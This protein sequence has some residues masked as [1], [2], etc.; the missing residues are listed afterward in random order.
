MRTR[1]SLSLLQN[2]RHGFLIATVAIIA[3]L[4]SIRTYVPLAD[5]Y[6]LSSRFADPGGLNLWIADNAIHRIGQFPIAWMIM[7]QRNWTPSLIS[8]TVHVL[9]CLTFFAVAAQ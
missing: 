7:Q 6:A 9:V 2:W 5:D 8:L 4:P 3:W 1:F